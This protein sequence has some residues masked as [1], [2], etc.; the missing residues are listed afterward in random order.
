MSS[1]NTSSESTAILG[2]TLIDG[3]GHAPMSNAAI[4]IEGG[5]IKE[6]GQ[7]DNV[8]LVMK[9]EKIAKNQLVVTQ[10]ATVVSM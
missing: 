8:D 1:P 9:A 5:R 10:R 2:A 4:V 7:R 6:V 3:T